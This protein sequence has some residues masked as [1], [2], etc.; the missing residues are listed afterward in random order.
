MVV[1]VVTTHSYPLRVTATRQADLSRSLWLI[2]WL[3]VIPHYV[4][5]LFL[6]IAFA[7]LS[8][9]A[10][11]VILFTGRY[12]RAIFD[13]NVGVLR[14][15]WR[16]AYYAYGALGTDRYPPFTLEDVPDYPAHLDISYPSRL[17]QGLV[18]V[19]W[20][21]LAIPHY[22]VVSVFLG[23]GLWLAGE[24]FGEGTVWVNGGGLIGLLVLIGAVVLLFTGTYPKSVF[25]L[26][27]GMNRWVLRV[28]AYA[29]L[30]TDVY[31]PF[32][33][34]QGPDDPATVQLTQAPPPDRSTAP[35]VKPPPTAP[36]PNG[37]SDGPW[38][39]AR[40]A[41]AAAGSLVLLLAGA[42]LAIGQT[43][44]DDDGFFMSGKVNVHTATYAI[45]TD[46]TE[47]HAGPADSLLPDRLVGDVRI[48]ATPVEG[49]ALFIGIA[50]AGDANR[51]L[52]GVGHATVT[53][54]RTGP[55][56]SD[57]LYRDSDGRPLPAALEDA[58]I[59][60][61]QSQGSGTR[62]LTW[63]PRS[64]DWVVVIANAD[65][66]QGVNV[67]VAAGAEVPA[68]KW[69]VAGLLSFGGCVLILG[70]VMFGAALR[71]SPVTRSERS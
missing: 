4:V 12:P 52:D 2:K 44:G 35:L 64:G 68:L 6:W 11:F 7:V 23:G 57:P 26:V 71:S 30:M 22:L 18:L 3:L 17:S 42:T 10:F 50:S 8:A 59:W 34:D 41:T 53:D 48:K 58:D 55:W 61:A 37:P 21:L 33:L 65:G 62:E 19:K 24:V 56:G 15:S 40:I 70:A 69:V 46:P 47:L 1:V 25:D 20:W 31:P 38:T 54:L 27:L 51:Y 60:V 13:F 14:W 28:A 16:V 45:A 36:S 49:G 29:A 67:D 39:G 66:R 32:R 9:V 5:L 43:L 63:T